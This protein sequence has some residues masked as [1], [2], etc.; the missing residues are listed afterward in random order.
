M[1]LNLLLWRLNNQFIT[2]GKYTVKQVVGIGQGDNHSGHLARLLMV[3]AE[4]DFILDTYQN[5]PQIAASFTCMR[6]K[7]DDIIFFNILE[8]LIKQ[9]LHRRLTQPGLY[10]YF[11]KVTTTNDSPFTNAPYLDTRVHIT[12][13]PYAGMQQ[14]DT[15]DDP[16]LGSMS[17]KQ[18]QQLA[19]SLHLKQHGTRLEVINRIQQF[20][21]PH[22]GYHYK[23]NIWALKSYNK[24][25]G[26]PSHIQPLTFPNINTNLPEHIKYGTVQGHFHSLHTANSHSTAD[27]INN[28]A[29]FLL[30]LHLKNGFP[31]HRLI[32]TLYTYTSKKVTLYSQPANRIGLKVKK[33]IY[34]FLKSQRHNRENSA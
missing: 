4:R 30:R 6:R 5:E 15:M 13:N 21:K 18:L 27:F 10:P 29:Q 2:I 17:Q 11:I 24:K 9:R 7:H 22:N 8:D 26:F 23:S 16:E 12:G 1:L 3:I 32:H 19:K 20:K 14:P 33:R 31:M 28:V 25:D 34:Q